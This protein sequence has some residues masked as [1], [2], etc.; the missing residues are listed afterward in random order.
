[1]FLVLALFLE[2]TFFFKISIQGFNWSYDKETSGITFKIKLLDSMNSTMN[3][4][5]RLYE[6]NI[7]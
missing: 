3:A 1:M 5:T 2:K 4:K 7:F 6:I